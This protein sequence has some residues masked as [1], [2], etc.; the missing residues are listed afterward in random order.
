ME[1]LDE[2]QAKLWIETYWCGE[3]G[4]YTNTCA[5]YVGN[6][7]STGFKSNCQWKYAYYAKR[8]AVGGARSN[9]SMSLEVFTPSLVK[10]ISD[11]S[12]KHAAK[13]MCS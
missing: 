6:K 9:M 3:H 5:D 7:K 1:S 12:E 13:T 2:L 11:A 8:D 10:H 4:K